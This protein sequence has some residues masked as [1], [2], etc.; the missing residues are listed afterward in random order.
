M[1][2]ALTSIIDACLESGE[3]SPSG[4]RRDADNGGVDT[5]GGKEGGG[6]RGGEAVVKRVTR[7]NGTGDAAAEG[8]RSREEG[9]GRRGEEGEARHSEEVL[10][11]TKETG[12]AILERSR[13]CLR[14]R[15][16]KPLDT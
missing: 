13:S 12:E 10:L 2:E 11:V 6:G 1:H 4:F 8:N 3:G 9:R 16:A 7:W 15:G 14:V 5:G